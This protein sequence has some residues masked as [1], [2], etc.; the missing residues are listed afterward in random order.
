MA[1]IV[2]KLESGDVETAAENTVEEEH[3]K[4]IESVNTKNVEMTPV[5]S[6]WK[7]VA[8][9]TTCGSPTRSSK[10]EELVIG[11]TLPSESELSHSRSQ[12]DSDSSASSPRSKRVRRV[13]TGQ[14]PSTETIAPPLPKTRPPS[15][16]KMKVFAQ[17]TSYYLPSYGQDASVEEKSL[18]NEGVNRQNTATSL[19]TSS[20]QTSRTAFS[21]DS[22][23][24]SGRGTA[25]TSRGNIR[26]RIAQ[27]ERQL[28]VSIT[29][30]KW[31]N[32]PQKNKFQK[33]C[34]KQFNDVAENRIKE[35]WDILCGVFVGFF[36]FFFFFKFGNL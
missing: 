35:P 13:A 36:F 9:A 22:V 28:Q 1:Q 10:Q 3:W 8:K 18:V 34:R 30:C 24:D 31:L 26:D 12:N 5:S 15:L 14:R 20:V 19:D 11:L 29:L 6:G 21:L 23:P 4:T 33:S 27:I 32:T 25:S 7:S 17:G 16:S 2:K